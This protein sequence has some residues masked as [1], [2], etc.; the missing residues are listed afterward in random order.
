MTR[1]LRT[2][3]VSGLAAIALVGAWHADAGAQE[4]TRPEQEIARHI[5][6]FK[7]GNTGNASAAQAALVRIGEPAV[8]ALI[9]AM[10]DSDDNVRIR[11]AGALEGLGAKAR[12]AVA[13]LIVGLKDPHRYVRSSCASALRKIGAG[14]TSAIPALIEVLSDDDDRTA[15][16]AADALA[17]M[18]PAAMPAIPALVR[19]LS[20]GFVYMSAR[21]A[22]K[23]LGAAA[24]PELARALGHPN[25]QVR[26]RA[27]WTLEDL[28]P[29]ATAAVTALSATLKDSD[30]GVR[31]GAAKA[32]AAIGPAARSA[33]AALRVAQSDA[34]SSVRLAAA[35]ALLKVSP[36]DAV[37][38]VATLAARLR[39]PDV[40]V[41]R[42][43]ISALRAIGAPAT[44]PLTALLRGD[45]DSEVRRRAAVALGELGPAA[46]PAVPALIEAMK[47]SAVKFN[48]VV[49]LGEIGGDA[50]VAPLAKLLDDER[51]HVNAAIGLSKLGPEAAAAV[52]ALTRALRHQDAETRFY[53]ASALGAIG[54]PAAG[55]VPALVPL[56]KDEDE[57]VRGMAVEVLGEFGGAHQKT[58]LAPLTEALRD[59]DKEVRGFAADALGQ[60]GEELSK[61]SDVSA[62]PGLQK[63]LR[64]LEQGNFE[65]KYIGN[66]RAALD[67]LVA[68]D[69]EGVRS[70]LSESEERVAERKGR[71]L[72][73]QISGRLD[74]EDVV[75]TG[76]VFGSNADRLYIATAR[77][78]VRQGMS[79]LSQPTVRL[80]M[81]PG[82]AIPA[83]LLE[84]SDR[85]L[86]L[87]VLEIRDPAQHRVVVSNILP[88]DRIGGTQSLE[89]NA[90]V[91]AVG[92]PVELAN[93]PAQAN[94]FDRS[95]GIQV[96]FESTTVRR[97]Y[98][99]GALFDSQWQ[100]IA[101]IRADEQPY[102]HAVA[103]EQI[104]A[105]LKDWGYPVALTQ[106]RGNR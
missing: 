54:S 89:P 16:E 64:A 48:A 74:G 13:A 50:V 18:G 47:D 62:I 21:R 42:D 49:A 45:G 100:L 43:A 73:V 82:E 77:H 106:Q 95:V 85:D 5:E 55:S 41:W 93:M 58:T 30:A 33:A 46:R 8:P 92:L 70:P 15:A 11:A 103:I 83:L 59:E 12:S 36:A 67:H 101:M 76:I 44:A 17:A 29:Q 31:R 34:D 51:Y 35:D 102:A 20:G 7:E 6:R 94:H 56:V 52:P 28:G 90:K 9:A 10:R 25:V 81:L 87:A 84:H 78:L 104:I 57:R 4:A 2:R 79:T 75:G 63:A 19:S 69:R 65:V 26:Q 3:I 97:G 1:E 72:V 14:A 61:G 24:A 32:L 66:V 39:D 71:S 96:V 91:Y 98:S 88:F 37:S 27:A 23:G 80:N 22:L 99:G 40:N 60:M 38:H 53:A 86:D 105:R 68:K